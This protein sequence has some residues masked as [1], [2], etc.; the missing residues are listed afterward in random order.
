ME[1]NMIENMPKIELHCHLDGSLREETVLEIVSGENLFSELSLSD[2]EKVKKVLVAPKDSDSLLDYLKS[3]DLPVGIMQTRESLERVSFELMEDAFEENI[4]YIEVRFAPLLHTKK[5]LDVKDVIESVLLGIHKAEEI[6]DIKGS[7]ILGCM[8]NMSEEDAVLV[9]EEGKKFL[10]AGV[11]AVDL[12]GPEEEGFCMKYKNA[13]A[14]AKEYG[15]RITVHAGEAA[16]GVNVFD[17]VTELGAE[18]IGHGVRTNDSKEI[19]ELVKSKNITLEMC[20]TSNV[21]TNAVKS[22]EEHPFYDFYR[23]GLRVTINTDN[24]TV[25]DVTLSSEIDFV[26]NYYNMTDED[27]YCMYKYAVEASFTNEDTKRWLLSFL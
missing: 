11:V 15:Y 13:F 22:F 27:Y 25:S 7:L 14:L 10:G 1:V 12:C 6:Y 20:P 19:Y 24:R 3:F 4:K 2:I 16:S 23:D 8:R 21:Q 17:A 9:I 18:R 5:G 26:L